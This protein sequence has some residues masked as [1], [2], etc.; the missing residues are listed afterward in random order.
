MIFIKSA[1]SISF[2]CFKTLLCFGN[3]S[4]RFTLKFEKFEL[5]RFVGIF[6]QVIL[7]GYLLLI[8]LFFCIPADSEG[9]TK[10]INKKR[11]NINFF[12]IPRINVNKFMKKLIN[13]EDF[14]GLSFGVLVGSL[15]RN[16]KK[17]PTK[18]KQ[19]CKQ[20]FKG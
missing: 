18:K 1:K 20:N 11:G 16:P 19:L 4:K 12:A 6:V 8:F 7:E 14:L 3:F 15:A 10:L 9:C 17:I 13:L 2:F 5:L